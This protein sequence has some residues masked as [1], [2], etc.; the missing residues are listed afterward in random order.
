M[1]AYSMVVQTN[2]GVVPCFERKPF[3]VGVE[4]LGAT[5]SDCLATPSK[6]L[7]A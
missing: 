1:S 3:G 4:V 6:S 2:V 5:Q 7:Y